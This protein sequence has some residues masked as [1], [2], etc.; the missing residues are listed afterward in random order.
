MSGSGVTVQPLANGVALLA[1]DLA[2]I[3]VELR[4]E[5]R[6]R[7]REAGQSVMDAAKGN[8]AWSSR[9]PGSLTLRT[10]FSERQAGVFIEANAKR[11]PH[12]RVYEGMVSDTFRHPVFQRSG[13]SRR[14]TPWVEQ[15]ARPFLWPAAQGGYEVVAEA[16]G[17]AVDAVL[18]AHG[19]GR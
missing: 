12:A 3:P 9:I 4:K 18:A 2:R 7:L 8:A 14:Q 15:A 13:Q 10:S 16:L 5:V 17:E 11:A 19:F 6:P 1:R